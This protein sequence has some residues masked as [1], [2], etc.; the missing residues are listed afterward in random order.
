MKEGISIKGQVID[1]HTHI[2]P[3]MDDGS[4]SLHTSAEMLHAFGEENVDVICATPHYFRSRESIARFVERRAAAA[5][6]FAGLYTPEKEEQYPQILLGAETAFFFGISECEDLD[7][8]C[9]EGT[10]TLL[11][12]MP[13]RKWSSTEISEVL[14]LK[15]DRGLKVILAHPER[16]E[17][18]DSNRKM[19]QKMMNLPMGIQVNADI[20][21]SLWSRRQG[22]RLLRE[23]AWPLLGSDAHNMQERRPRLA[24][25]R[26]VI[27]HRLGTT[28][29]EEMDENTAWLLGI[30]EEDGT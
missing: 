18:C 16:Y 17:F 1:L 8:L 28:F 30:Q 6:L 7:A 3:E 26:K 4:D 15:L 24:E 21:L 14:S 23:A 29:L 20:L 11:L 12:E 9:I 19:L 27:A 22:L 10:K 13:F 5:E 25:G 2:L